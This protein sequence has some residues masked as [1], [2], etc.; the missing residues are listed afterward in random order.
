MYFI[1]Y[2]YGGSNGVGMKLP[3]TKGPYWL[4]KKPMNGA[5]PDIYIIELTSIHMV[6]QKILNKSRKT[7]VNSLK[8]LKSIW[9]KTQGEIAHQNL[10]FIHI[11][12][13]KILVI[14]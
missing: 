7:T 11:M 6:I 3:I 9:W 2:M 8:G 13:Q 14:A 1:Y 4:V 5:L 10:T 12:T